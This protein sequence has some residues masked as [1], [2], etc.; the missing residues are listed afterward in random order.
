M[1]HVLTH[2]P[3][4]ANQYLAE[5]RHIETQKDR[6][7][8][9][10]N[11][12]RIGEV[13]G[14]EISKTLTYQNKEVETSLGVAQTQLLVEQPVLATIIR[15]G[16]PMHHGML[17]VFDRSACAFVAAYRKVKKSGAFEVRTEYLNTPDLDEKTVIICDP[18]LAT[19]QSMVLACK[20]LMDKFDIK[21]LHIAVAIASDEGINHVRAYL[22]NA[23]IWVG[24]VD[25]ELTSKSYIVPG[26]GDAGDLAYG[27]KM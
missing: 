14:T 7:R 2:F 11:L 18:M 10:F 24:D 25:A 12:E 5:L 19:G 17:R 21:T 27:E 15:A 1:V 9:R 3:S 16:I 20:E 13:L 4:I 8:F 23:Y 26:L 6:M 22:P